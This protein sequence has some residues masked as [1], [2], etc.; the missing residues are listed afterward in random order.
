MKVNDLV[1]RSNDWIIDIKV[2]C[3]LSPEEENEIGLIT[4]F[5]CN[6]AVILW[7][8]TGLSWENIDDIE[9]INESR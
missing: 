8:Y 5:D 2:N 4:K 6:H 1:R 3:Y 7:S 9:V